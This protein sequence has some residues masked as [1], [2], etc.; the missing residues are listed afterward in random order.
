MPLAATWLM[1]S[2]EGPYIAAIVARMPDVVVNLAAYGV[3]FSLAWMSEAP[4]MMLLSASNA[5]VRDRDS[6]LAMKQFTY[7]LIL[8]TTMLVLLANVPVVFDFFAH[9]IMALPDEVSRLVHTA[10]LILVPWPGAIGYRR[11]YQGILVRNR[12]TR[13]VA[14]GTIVRL[15]A[16]SASAASLAFFSQLHGATI[17]AIALTSGVVCEALASRWMARHII[18]SLLATPAP[19]GVH[20]TQR[21]IGQFYVPL[22]LTSI[23]SMT[24][25]PMLTFFMGHSRN[26]IESLAVLPIVQ[27]MVFIFRSGGVAY[28]EVGVALT[29]EDGEHEREVARGALFLGSIA[30][31]A[32]MIL[33]LTPLIHVWLINVSGLTPE[34]ASFAVLPA[35]LLVFVPL[36]EYWLS[37]QRSRF[38][39][40][41]GTRLIT[42]ATMIEVS[43]I[44]LVLI[45]CTRHFGMIGVIA[46]S[47]AMMTGR[48][49]SN[50]FL[51]FARRH[52]WK[53]NLPRLSQAIRASR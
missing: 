44:A 23:I 49:A 21:A 16:M 28:Q 38:I 53:P 15:T 31:V 40:T 43:S 20:L 1:M 46:G 33:T 17:G 5:L 36:M 11:F 24:T 6:F 19:E 45:L 13:R 32:L 39:L 9:D 48:S 22:A 18:K 26:P 30:S 47:V 7:R 4:I 2:V 41:K 10:M 8:G 27:N 35:Q 34:L 52:G 29:G 12:M 50:T 3:A 14:Y 42:L 37:F 25:G 51:Y